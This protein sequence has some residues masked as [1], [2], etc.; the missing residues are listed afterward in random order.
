MGR[1]VHDLVVE[2]T[3]GFDVTHVS[4]VGAGYRV[5]RADLVKH[6]VGELVGS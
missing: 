4:Y 5:E 6:L 1:V 2:R 3:V